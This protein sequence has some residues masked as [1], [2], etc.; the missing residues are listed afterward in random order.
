M[1]RAHTTR[2]TPRG[3]FPLGTH[4]VSVVEVAGA[5]QLHLGIDGFPAGDV[6]LANIFV[7]P[8]T[9]DQLR[10]LADAV[11]MGMQDSAGVPE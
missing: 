8:D 4:Q 6:L 7:G 1:M 11:D 5:V 2:V 10:A 9:A 3:V